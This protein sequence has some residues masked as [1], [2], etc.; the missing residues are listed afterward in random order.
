MNGLTP[1]E[2]SQAVSIALAGAAM[3]LIGAFP[4]PRWARL[5]QRQMDELA[6]QLTA[7]SP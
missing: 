2:L 7:P 4:L 3:F 5:R 6:E 1:G